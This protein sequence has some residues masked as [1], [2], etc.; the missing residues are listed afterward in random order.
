MEIRAKDALG[1][2]R[3]SHGKTESGRHPPKSGGLGGAHAMSWGSPDMTRGSPH[4]IRGGSLSSL[5]AGAAEAMSAASSS[6]SISDASPC[7][8]RRLNTIAPA[9]PP[10]GLLPGTLVRAGARWCAR[11]ASREF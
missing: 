11:V 3:E 4:M 5:L 8:C 2:G 6:S 9:L 7:G 1:K 10:D